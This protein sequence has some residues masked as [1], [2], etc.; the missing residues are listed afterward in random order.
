MYYIFIVPNR[1]DAKSF[2]TMLVRIFF[3]GGGGYNFIFK[4]NLWLVTMGGGVVCDKNVLTQVTV[5]IL[6]VE[7]DHQ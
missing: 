2:S 1:P 4:Y 6:G 5:T 7:D 3:N